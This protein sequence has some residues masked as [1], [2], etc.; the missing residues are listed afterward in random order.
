MTKL[1]LSCVI[2]LGRLASAQELWRIGSFDNSYDEFACAR[3]YRAFASAFQ[4]DPVFRI[5]TSAEKKD[6][7]FVNPGPADHWAGA[8]PHPFTIEFDL[9]EPPNRPLRLLVDLVDVQG[10]VPTQ[11]G[12]RVN[13]TEGVFRLKNGN[14]RS[15]H[16]PAAGTE[17]VVSLLLAPSMM[18]V[19]KNLIALW[20]TGSW[21]LYD[22]ISLSI[23]G[24]TDI[25]PKVRAVSAEPTVL[26]RRL[27]GS[28]LA[29]VVVA[30][31]EVEG[32]PKGL[33]LTAKSSAG[34]TVTPVKA[35]ISFGTI[36]Q[37]LLVPEVDRETPLEIV[38][39]LGNTTARTE[40]VVKPERKWR[41]FVA[42]SVHTDIGY[43]D[44]QDR[45]VERH[46]DNTDRA[47][48]LCE[49]FPAFG[50]NLETAWQAHVYRE[51]RS[52]KQ[53]EKLYALA[54]EGRIEIEASYLN[55]LTGL[56]SHEELNRWLY[57][58]HSLKRRYGVPFESALIT[59]VPTQAWSVPSTLAAAGIRYYATG[60][61]TT[62]AYTFTQLMTGHPYWWEGPDG[63]RLLAYFAPGYAH[64]TG[65]LS[66]LEDLR[67]WVLANTQ[68]RQ[69]FP[70]DALFLYG[71][72]GDNQPIQEN[73]AQTAQQWADTYEYPKLIVGPNYHYFRYMEETYGQ[74][75]P[76]V[77]GDGGYYWEDGA[78]SSAY[79]TALN[80]NAHET[81]VA[82]DAALA[83]ASV[84]GGSQAPKEAL[85]EMW[86]N[87][88]L[89]D[90][91]TWGAYM[92][93]TEPDNPF[94]TD[95]WEVKSSFA[96]QADRQTKALLAEGLERLARLIKI[97]CPA[98]LLFNATS[99]PR[100]AHVMQVE[101]PVGMAPLDP[102]TRQPLPAV[103]LRKPDGLSSREVV[104]FRTPVIPCWGYALCPLE[105]ADLPEAQVL[106]VEGEPNIENEYLRVTVDSVTGGLASIIDRTTGQEFAD[107]APYR[108]N[109]YLYV[110][111]GDGTNIV[112]IAANKPAQLTVHEP[113]GVRLTKT[114]LPGLGTWITAEAQAQNTP[115]LIS[116][117][118]LYNGEP[119]L[120]IAN[121]VTREA[122]RGK[123]AAYFAFPFAATYPEFRL[124]IPN[125]VMRPGVDELPGSCKEW[126]AVQHFVR[127][128]SRDGNLVLT[129]IDA[130][131]VCLCDINRGLWPQELQ[132]SNAHLYSYIMN[133]YWFTNYKADQDGEV[134]FRYAI[135]T[136]A[137]NDA[138]AARFGWQACAP[139]RAALIASAQ[140]GPLPGTL[141]SLCRVVPESVVITAIKAPEVGSGLVL[142]LFS[143]AEKPTTAALTL[144]VPG[145]RKAHL[146]NLVEEPLDELRIVGGKIKVRVKPM[147]PVTVVVKR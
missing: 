145:L 16:D 60:I 100:P 142:R 24:E 92:S 102:S 146:C 1:L 71:G 133:N 93:V 68:N 140:D 50:W 131:L 9:P 106:P 124:E 136:R 23:A 21:F 55:M 137:G 19:G 88:L 103:R 144:S 64:A 84:L 141:T 73:V 30:Q 112:D 28:G 115:R 118:A 34:T 14:E 104:L 10:F 40:T 5:G 109:E 47:I 101:L 105:A 110:S 63:S 35:A 22:A 130:P 32:S 132:I 135:T 97:D 36:E 38:A 134:T 54:R 29:Q 91:H 26:F 86:Q 18:R 53:C 87:I 43:T 56:C 57:Y 129:P 74:K 62:R 4:R 122:E 90:E 51:H 120:N 94:S 67:N 128:A 76:V 138:E 58:A 17:Q 116:V 49:K 96:R 85:G 3:N 80:R 45:V 31:V 119:W 42:P 20:S 61:N 82:A 37:E 7:S 66:S 12:V 6:W 77:R 143:Y 52:R 13:G 125:G 123:E 107:S 95:Q 75:I 44:R 113:T 127:L 79:E 72:F 15:I 8:R 41:I 89:Y 39:E 33:T 65:P 99:W 2:S 126:Y 78:A 108:L 98:L 11:L 48:E 59:D 114:V 25:T 83:F 121:N 27:P 139:V 117:Y 147:T 69:D 81:A 70:Y 46:N 111:G